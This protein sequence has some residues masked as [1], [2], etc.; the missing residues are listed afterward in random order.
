MDYR[1]TLSFTSTQFSAASTWTRYPQ[2]VFWLGF[3]LASSYFIQ[4]LATFVILT[5][6]S[7][8]L[9]TNGIANEKEREVLTDLLLLEGLWDLPTPASEQSQ[10]SVR[11][12]DSFPFARSSFPLSSKPLH[13]G[14]WLH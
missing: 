11:P 8:N 10:S 1:T 7:D 14:A 3:I 5:G 4:P 13:G 12:S 9:N 6:E 2:S